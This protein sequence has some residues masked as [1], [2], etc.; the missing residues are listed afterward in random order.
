MEM[1]ASLEIYAY[2]DAESFVVQ[3]FFFL[4]LLFKMCDEKLEDFLGILF[5]LFVHTIM[6]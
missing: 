1:C 5:N 4:L 3:F 6:C 2:V